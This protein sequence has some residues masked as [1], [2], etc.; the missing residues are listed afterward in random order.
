MTNPI[1]DKLK[2]ESIFLRN[3]KDNY[4]IPMRGLKI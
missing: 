3:K 2:G 4:P 1:Y